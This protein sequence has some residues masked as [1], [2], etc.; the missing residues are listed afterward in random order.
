V[1]FDKTVPVEYPL[2]VERRKQFYI[3]ARAIKNQQS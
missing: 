1:I 2:R 3:M